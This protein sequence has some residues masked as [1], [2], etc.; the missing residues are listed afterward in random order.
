V[1]LPHEDLGSVRARGHPLALGHRDPCG[2]TGSQRAG[3]LQLHLVYANGSR[4]RPARGDATIQ[5]LTPGPVD[6][7]LRIYS[8]LGERVADFQGSLRE[9]DLA[10]TPR[11]QDT[12]GLRYRV[13]VAWNGR[14]REGARA[15][16]GAYILHAVLASRDGKADPATSRI[17]KRKLIFG[18]LRD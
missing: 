13:Q 2:V 5:I 9:T 14:T 1:H 18:L 17:H 4:D 11:V 6:Y 10:Q 12:S 3:S 7:R 8:N 15:G 16:T